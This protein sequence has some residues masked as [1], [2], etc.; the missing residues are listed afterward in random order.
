L[1][2]GCSTGGGKGSVGGDKDSAG[3]SKGAGGKK[4]KNNNADA[5]KKK[6]Y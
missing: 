2:P 5:D 1:L 3:S 6:I 4:V